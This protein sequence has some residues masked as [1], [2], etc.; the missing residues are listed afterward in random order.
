MALVVLPIYSTTATVVLAPADKPSNGHLASQ[1]MKQYKLRALFCPPTIFEQLVAEPEGLEQAKQLDF[2]LYAG[3]PLSERTGDL[4]SQVTDV[5]Q[6]YGSTETGAVP[7]LVPRRNDWA[8][9]EWHPAFGV[10]MQPAEDD[11]YEFV[12]R[13]DPNLEG[14]RS[15]SCNFPDVDEWHTRDL[16]RPVPGKPHLWRF[17]GRRDD[18]I[19]LSNGEKFNPVPSE[20]IIAGHPLLSAALIVGLG[21]FQAALLIEPKN[22]AGVKEADLI[23]EVWP[24]V[25]KA[26]AQA[27][28]QA[29]ITRSMIAVARTE[30][31]F[32]RAGKGTVIR[33]M[34]AEKFTPEIEALYST[35]TYK[36]YGPQLA[37][38]DD[39]GAYVRACVNLSFPVT[40]LD[41]AE[42]L[43]VRGLDSLK[44]VE[45]M[46]ILRA[47][48]GTSNTSWLSTQTIYANPTIHGLSNVIS[49]Q[50]NPNTHSSND[51]QA[52]GQSRTANMAFLVQKYTQ[53]LPTTISARRVDM[54][55]SDLTVVL[56]GSTGSLGTHILRALL[57]DP[58]ISKIQCLNRSADARQRQFESLRRLGSSHALDSPSVEFMKVEYGQILLGLAEKQY[59]KLT[60][61][62]DIIIHNAWK[63]DFNHSLESFE[64]F[65]IRGVRNLIDWSASSS[66]HPHII[67]ISSISSIGN[68]KHGPSGRQID[69]TPIASHDS[70]QEM[71]YGESKNVAECI[72]DIAN[73]QAG[74][75]V[76]I[77][78]LGQIAG[79]VTTSGIWNEAEWFPSLVKTSQSQ[80]C[81]PNYLPKIDWIPVDLLAATILDIAHFAMDTNQPQVYNIV[82]PNIAE[83]TSLIDSVVKRLGPWIKVVE[84]NDWI[85]MVAKVNQENTRE[86]AAK[87]AAK[88]LD[89]F[90]DF[91]GARQARKLKYV[92]DNA[93]A[94]SKTLRD[95]GPVSPRWMEIWLDQWGY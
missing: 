85:D 26:N 8:S 46:S 24:T 10:D 7:A 6:F 38:F 18:I 55:R 88:I 74:V 33:K 22:E 95:I 48:L 89:F 41:E 56:T 72:L 44:T 36:G 13:K 14:H 4:L 77:L 64:P 81:I 11:A 92:A 60:S 94:V 84:L 57:D 70:A 27:P 71:G 42:D 51:A 66:R 82:N 91:E 90:K 9:L 32:E 52:I 39:M 30:K 21:R 3:G 53:D 37:T 68:W 58:K 50:L 49:R 54:E 59:K 20:T 28:G 86:L 19:V 78:R 67:F 2:L 35:A 76:S 45:L 93:I 73:K 63:V 40:E 5:C 80:G 69:E 83:W 12:L 43:Y 25:E 75:P 34:T 1:I 65:H 87:P 31:R 62:V 29:R 23:E 15:L 79:P 47:G 16:F 17:H 61:S